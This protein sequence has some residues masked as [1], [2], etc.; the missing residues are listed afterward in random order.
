MDRAETRWMKVCEPCRGLGPGSCLAHRGRFRG[1][2]PLV[3]GA[4]ER[5][6]S[7]PVRL[8]SIRVLAHR[9]GVNSIRMSAD[10]RSAHVGG[11]RRPQSLACGGWRGAA[12]AGDGKGK[13]HSGGRRA[14]RFSS[15]SLQCVRDIGAPSIERNRLEHDV[16]RRPIDQWFRDHEHRHARGMVGAL[17][18]G[19]PRDDLRRVWR[20]EVRPPG[21]GP[22]APVDREHAQIADRFPDRPDDHAGAKMRNAGRREPEVKT[23]RVSHGGVA[24]GDVN[25]DAVRRLDIRERGNNHPP[26]ALDGVERQKTPM[27]LDKRAHHRGFSRG[28]KRRTAALTGLDLDQ[29]INDTPPLHQ[30][31]VHLQIDSVDLH[32]QIGESRLRWLGHET[33]SPFEGLMEIRLSES[34]SEAAQVF[35]DSKKPAL[36]FVSRT[37]LRRN[38]IAPTAP[39]GLKIR[40][41]TY[42]F[43]RMSGGTRSSSFR[44]PDRVMSIDGKV[45]LSATFRSRMISELPVPLNSSKMTSSMREPVSIN[46]VAMMVIDPPSSMFRAAPKNRFGRWSAL[47]STP[48]VRTFPD[49]G[50]TVL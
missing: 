12:G 34:C 7:W 21:A 28:A 43:F 47:A 41:S 32:P 16:T 36:L 17:N 14:Y 4:R 37:L 6:K 1:S 29:L 13:P 3:E 33:P 45:R 31:L 46:A 20:S 23:R 38:W 40:L 25:M 24:P 48:P 10:L 22:R 19:Q 42:I 8:A 26:D 50:T 15:N 9:R 11:A 2:P 49:E 35:I 27:S 44:V 30:E 39:T 18:K 5:W